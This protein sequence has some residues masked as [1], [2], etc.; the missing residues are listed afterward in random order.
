MLQW[1][2]TLHLNHLFLSFLISIHSSA[3]EE[4][5]AFIKLANIMEMHLPSKPVYWKENRKT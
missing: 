4:K 5:N 1:A 2:K 3:L